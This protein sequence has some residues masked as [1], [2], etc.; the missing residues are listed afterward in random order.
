MTDR[1]WRGELAEAMGVDPAPSPGAAEGSAA[2]DAPLAS[3]AAP[4]PSPAVGSG[5]VG[6]AREVADR[7]SVDVEA[8]LARI[9]RLLEADLGLLG[10]A[11]V[12]ESAEGLAGTAAE[13]FEICRRVL[14]RTDV[15][16]SQLTDLEAT[17][18]AVLQRL[19]VVSGQVQ[20]LLERLDG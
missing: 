9:E 4:A 13:L 15:L 8:R 12:A 16:D 20:Q 19:E 18:T 7:S 3:P 6:A 11:V 17:N 10:G 1:N 2:H 14:R 5:D